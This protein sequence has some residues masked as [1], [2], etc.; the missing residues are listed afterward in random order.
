MCSYNIHIFIKDEK[1]DLI[2]YYL[3]T[4]R[5]ENITLLR[6]WQNENMT[7]LK[8]RMYVSMCASK[9]IKPKI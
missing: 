6:I 3:R 5:Q 1:I 4:N 2:Y 8:I 9:K 7:P